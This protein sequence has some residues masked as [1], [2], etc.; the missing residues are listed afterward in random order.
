MP[1]STS[2]AA[3]QSEGIPDLGLL[4]TWVLIIETRSLAQTARK[5][6][7]SRAAVSQ[8]LKMLESGMGTEL[9]VHGT[10][11]VQPT[12]AGV[13][14][15]EHASQVLRQ[16]RIMQDAMNAFHAEKRRIVRFGTVDSFAST[17]GPT[18]LKGLSGPGMPEI[19]L[20]S[21]LTPELELQLE[22]H[23]IDL[24]VTTSPAIGKGTLRKQALFSERYL[25]ALPRDISV[26][27]GLT[28]NGLSSRLPLIRYGVRSV[29]GHD[30][31]MYLDLLG[32]YVAR[33]FE[34]DTTGPMLSLVSAGLGF[35]ITTPLCAWDLRHFIPDIRLL[36]MSS[37]RTRPGG[38]RLSP[39][40]RTFYLG[41]R[42]NEPL[43]IRTQAATVIQRAAQLLI[44]QQIA[45]ALGIDA[46]LLWQSHFRTIGH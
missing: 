24:T 12:V 42:N 23:T 3:F 26:D 2:D 46:A 4:A 32:E 21:G 5:L 10:R 27:D 13:E 28:L 14:L 44:G 1:S 45:P 29:I 15:F 11:P 36:P 17:L 35:T 7:I 9:M 30:I 31:D 18:L 33:T 20:S 22:R 25:L 37:L 8:R 19:R 6:N 43:Y 41:Y 34:F 39:P 16:V 38:Q 40:D